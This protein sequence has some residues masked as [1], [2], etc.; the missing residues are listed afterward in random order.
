MR[1]NSIGKLRKDLDLVL[2]AQRKLE[3]RLNILFAIV[4]F[5][6]AGVLYTIL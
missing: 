2:A 1:T 4:I 5:C 6:T 3:T